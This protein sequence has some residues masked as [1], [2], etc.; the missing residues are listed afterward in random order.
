MK[1][2]LQ[3]A[4][5]HA[6]RRCSGGPRRCEP[7]AVDRPAPAP[8]PA[9]MTSLDLVFQIAYC[10]PDD[11]KGRHGNLAVNWNERIRTA[12]EFVIEINSDRPREPQGCGLVSI[13]AD[14]RVWRLRGA[15]HRKAG[16]ATTEEFGGLPLEAALPVQ[17]GDECVAV[18]SPYVP[19][20]CMLMN[21]LA[22]HSLPLAA[23]MVSIYAICRRAAEIA[24][25]LS[26]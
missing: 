12:V 21:G 16:R 19:I 14:F 4:P 11:A 1:G 25:V 17:P 15:G 18:K 6:E 23:S 10:S 26:I 8:R 13:H 20:G 24:A 7:E 9:L 3:P 22:A 2:S 5:L